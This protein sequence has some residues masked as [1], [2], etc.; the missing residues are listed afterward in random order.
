MDLRTTLTMAAVAAASLGCTTLPSP[1]ELDAQATAMIKAAF[2][3]EG[4]AKVDR[5]KQDLGQQACSGDKPP[6]EALA[7][8]IETE[9]LATI[10]W[11]A[12]GQY[13][14][15]RNRVF[16]HHQVAR[17]RPVPGRLA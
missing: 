10:K 2:R 17:R 3:D 5:I 12:G 13:Q 8:Q 4:I 1:Q 15:D 7:K 9:S 11:P 14:A 16:G 6:A